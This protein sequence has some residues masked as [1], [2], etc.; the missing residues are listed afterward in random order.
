VIGSGHFVGDNDGRNDTAIRAI[1]AQLHPDLEDPDCKMVSA[2]TISSTLQRRRSYSGKTQMHLERK[3][4]AKSQLDKLEAVRELWRRKGP[5]GKVHNAILFCIDYKD[6]L[7][8][9]SYYPKN[10]DVLRRQVLYLQ[11]SG[12]LQ[13]NSKGTQITGTTER[14][15]KRCLLRN[16][17]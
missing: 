7:K 12:G 9:D 8:E 2:S 14:P 17:S 3:L 15:E 11:P 4:K 1:L 6:D 13:S 5:L 10:W 16:I